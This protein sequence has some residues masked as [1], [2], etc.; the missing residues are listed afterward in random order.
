MEAGTDPSN[1]RVHRRRPGDRALPWQQENIH[2][3][4][5]ARMREMMAYVSETLA[6]RNS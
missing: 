4:D 2:V 6:S 5:T 1:E 3:I